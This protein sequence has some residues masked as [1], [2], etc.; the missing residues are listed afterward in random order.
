MKIDFE[1][2]YDYDRFWAATTINGVL[3]EAY[4]DEV[5]F[6]CACTED[7][8]LYT[9]Q[10]VER[11]EE[12]L[13]TLALANVLFGGRPFCVIECPDYD[14]GH[15][16]DVAKYGYETK[17]FEYVV[18]EGTPTEYAQQSPVFDEHEEPAYSDPVD[19]EVTAYELVDRLV[20]HGYKF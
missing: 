9:D 15:Y 7:E 18:F 20:R 11:L 16:L 4:S 14:G 10:A 3:F 5:P 8:W 6:G 19:T 2:G 1:T 17:D 12:K 13:R